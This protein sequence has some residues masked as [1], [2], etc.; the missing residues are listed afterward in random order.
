MFYSISSHLYSKRRATVGSLK[1]AGAQS[2]VIGG[3]PA[4]GRAGHCPPYPADVLVPLP[5][6][7]GLRAH[8]HAAPH[9]GALPSAQAAAVFGAH[10]HPGI[11]CLIRVCLFINLERKAEICQERMDMDTFPLLSSK[12]KSSIESHDRASPS[13]EA[14]WERKAGVLILMGTQGEGFPLS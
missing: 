4:G 5:G 11:P 2:L 12:H 13:T 9:E 7:E 14:T 6:G 3:P 8:D 1:T 10:G